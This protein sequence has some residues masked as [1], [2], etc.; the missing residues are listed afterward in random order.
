M[1]MLSD[2]EMKW[3]GEVDARENAATPGAW[4]QCFHVDSVNADNLCPCGYR[5]NIMSVTTDAQ[6]C[7][8]GVDDTGQGAD[9]L[10]RSP[11]AMQVADAHFIAHARTDIPRMRELVDRLAL[12]VAVLEHQR[13]ALQETGTELVEANRV[14]Q[15]RCG[16][17]LDLVN[18][19]K[20]KRHLDL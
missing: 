15:R 19:M 14:W 9:M 16:E 2:E 5:G 20:A 13:D 6:V 10:G 17:C 12:R 7:E 11:R 8:L 3:L 1:S 18:S 4:R